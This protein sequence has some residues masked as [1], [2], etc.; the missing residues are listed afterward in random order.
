MPE[1]NEV[2]Y[3]IYDQEFRNKPS[4]HGNKFVTDETH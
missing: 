4:K 3:L 1:K 2:S